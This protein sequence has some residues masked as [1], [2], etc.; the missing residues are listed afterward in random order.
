MSGAVTVVR[1]DEWWRSRRRAA[2]VAWTALVVVVWNVVFDA[3]VIQSGRDYLTL[4]ALH[5]QGRGVAV[6]IPGVMRPGIVR[7]F[8]LATLVAG[9]VAALGALLWW[10]A[11]RQRG[12]RSE[13]PAEAG[14]HDRTQAR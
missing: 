3:V 7:G 5:Q 10:V 2:G 1:G 13:N 8:W 11:S 4:Q 9:S 14:F 12:V 6:S